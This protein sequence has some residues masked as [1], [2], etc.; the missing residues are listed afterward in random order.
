MNNKNP[1]ELKRKMVESVK[2]DY[3]DRAEGLVNL[4]YNYHF[5]GCSY[6]NE[7]MEIINSWP[8]PDNSRKNK[9]RHPPDDS[10]IKGIA[11]LNISDNSNDDKKT[12]TSSNKHLRDYD[13]PQ[14]A[15]EDIRY[16][17]SN[18][19]RGRGRGRGRGSPSKTEPAK[20]EFVIHDQKKVNQYGNF[21]KSSRFEP[22]SKPPPVNNQSTSQRRRHDELQITKVLPSKPSM[23]TNFCKPSVENPL[24]APTPPPEVIEVPDETVFVDPYKIDDG[25]EFIKEDLDISLLEEFC[26]NLVNYSPSHTTDPVVLMK[27]AAT[28]SR[29]KLEYHQTNTGS[30]VIDTRGQKQIRKTKNEDYERIEDDNIGNKLLRSMGWV[31]GSGLGKDQQ[32]IVA[33]IKNMGQVS[34]HG[35]GT[36]NF[37]PEHRKLCPGRMASLEIKGIY[38][39]HGISCSDA[40]AEAKCAQHAID[41]LTKRYNNKPSH[42]GTFAKLNHDLD[43]KTLAFQLHLRENYNAVSNLYASAEKSGAKISFIDLDPKDNNYSVMVKI[44]DNFIACGTSASPAEAK[45]AGAKQAISHLK[46][47]GVAQYDKDGA[48][49]GALVLSKDGVM[50]HN[51]PV[52]EDEDWDAETAH[53]EYNKSSNGWNGWDEEPLPAWDTEANHLNG[54]P[55]GHEASWRSS[56]NPERQRI[57]DVNK[58]DMENKLLDFVDNPNIQE[59]SFPINMTNA[60]R[61]LV[62]ALAGQYGLQSRSKGRH[63]VNRQLWVYKKFTM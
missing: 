42:S 37:V 54:V 48:I 47:Q 57:S 41:Y 40:L 11:V 55:S 58:S 20:A 27:T 29:V 49:E 6:N 25:I 44:N 7:L 14:F 53:K 3:G 17:S 45:L 22:A 61:K 12:G 34:R 9:N 8:R 28:R 18:V 5:G 30:M 24:R 51:W 15:S 35:L 59:L 46:A 60:D 32:G 36:E 13:R 2:A 62:H 4:W 10:A 1:V 23:Y 56:S 39:A 26:Y 16:K 38:V 52:Q 19:S 33:P 50:E 63:G 43:I 21:S 31:D